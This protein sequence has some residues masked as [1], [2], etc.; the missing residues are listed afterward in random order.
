MLTKSVLVLNQNY[1]PISICSAKK[2]V[3]LMILEKAQ[4]IERYNIEIHS[5]NLEI[6]YPSVIRLNMYVRKPFQKVLTGR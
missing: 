2:A 1:V 5:V 6:P 3:I 4:M